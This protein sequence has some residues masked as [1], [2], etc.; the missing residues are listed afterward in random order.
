VCVTLRVPQA[1]RAQMSTISSAAASRTET[2]NKN[3]KCYQRW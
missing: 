2:T 3:F 1:E